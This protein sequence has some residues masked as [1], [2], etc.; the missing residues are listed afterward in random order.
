MPSR[1]RAN[2]AYILTYT[3]RRFYPLDANQ[4][5]V[6]ITDIAHALAYSCRFNGHVSQFYSV[7][8]HSV[9]ASYLC[10]EDP[11]WALMHDAAEAYLPDIAR[12]I[13]QHING[14]DAI[15]LRLLRVIAAAFSLSPPPYSESVSRV[16]DRL[17]ATEMRDLMHGPVDISF[18]PFSW[19]IVPW[20]PEVSEREFLERY[21]YLFG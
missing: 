6:C 16:D 8:Q 5:D 3:N 19:R 1:A 13:K 15:E 10:V 9:L 18:E 12:P 4:C 14:F 20:S 2:T 7:A 11:R 21:S 17:L